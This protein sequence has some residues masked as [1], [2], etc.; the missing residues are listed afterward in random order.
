MSDTFSRK[1]KQSCE[2]DDRNRI[3]RKDDILVNAR[4]VDSNTCRH[5]NK[6][7]VEPRSEEDQ[8]EDCKG[9]STPGRF[10]LVLLRFASRL[11]IVGR[12]R[13]ACHSGNR[14]ILGPWIKLALMRRG[15]RP[16]ADMI[17]VDVRVM[18]PL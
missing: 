18:Y 3:E 12:S 6:E 14:S 13:S 11:D 17:W 1:G 7:D 10:R 15:M 4:E 8:F 9:A 2:R 5:E 16:R